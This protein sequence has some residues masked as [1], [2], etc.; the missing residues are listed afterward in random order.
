V[1][2]LHKTLTEEDC[3]QVVVLTA[4][5]AANDSQI[6]IFPYPPKKELWVI[7]MAKKLDT[8]DPPDS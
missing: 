2:L 5:K 7:A 6:I 8:Y 3:L 4:T 1:Y